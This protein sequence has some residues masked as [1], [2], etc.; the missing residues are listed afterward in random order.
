MK[1]CNT[2]LKFLQKSTSM[3]LCYRGSA[4]TLN[5][6][7]SVIKNVYLKRIVTK[8]LLDSD[9]FVYFLIIEKAEVLFTN[10][11]TSYHV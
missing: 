3:L 6:V 10:N 8:W 1:F 7:S 9:S 5:T 4:L 11:Y 2:E